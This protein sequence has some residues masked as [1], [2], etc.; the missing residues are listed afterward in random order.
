[1]LLGVV[2]AL[3]L[4]EL[5]LRICGF[6][7][8]SI[9]SPK[10]K[11]LGNYTIFCL[12]ESTTWGVGARNPSL[13]SYPRQLEG[14]LAVMYKS[15]GIKVIYDQTIGQNTSEISNKLPFYIE[16]YR[17]QI[18]IIM[19][20]ANNFWNL[21][22]SNILLFN[23]NKYIADT[24][25]NILMFLDK[26]RI[27]KLYKWLSL[28]SGFYKHRWN[29]YYPYSYPWYVL[30]REMEREYNGMGIFYKIADYDIREMVK[31]CKRNGI[32]LII[33][34]YP[35][36]VGAPLDS[37]QKKI[38]TDFQVVFVDNKKIFGELPNAKDYFSTDKWHPNE[39]GYGILAENVYDAIV[40]NKLL[41]KSNNGNTLP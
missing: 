32:K 1:M 11:N 34:N 25:L 26:F 30:L 37:L 20:G 31:T 10:Q 19:C 27:W 41:Q 28:N 21:D 14:K 36:G 7:Y 22:K 29:Y 17:P 12:G 39:E 40:K 9:Y 33:C 8:K 23:K 18:V 24:A 3:I 16:K 6:V 38:A 2:A 4:V 13:Q 35:G 15:L 5:L